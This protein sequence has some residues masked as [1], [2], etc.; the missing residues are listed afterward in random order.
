MTNTDRLYTAMREFTNTRRQNRDIYLQTKKRLDTY[1]G[2][3]GYQADLD[4]AMK[5][6]RDADESARKICK[7]EVTEALDSMLI[8]I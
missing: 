8:K 5:Q 2:S 1:K 6:R 3:E 4:K 7:K